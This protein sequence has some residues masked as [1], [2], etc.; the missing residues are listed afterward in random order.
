M[1][2]CE[3]FSRRECAKLELQKVFLLSSSVFLATKQSK[4]RREIR[5]FNGKLTE[6][7]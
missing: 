1:L 7:E 2:P 5:K 4:E 6:S 3:L